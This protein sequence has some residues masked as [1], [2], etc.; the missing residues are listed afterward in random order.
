LITDAANLAVTTLA[1]FCQHISDG[2]G[3]AYPWSSKG[4]E[5][6]LVPVDH[7]IKVLRVKLESRRRWRRLDLALDARLL[8]N[9]GSQRT[10]RVDS[11]MIETYKF[12]N[13]SR[14]RP[15]W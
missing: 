5:H 8:G 11:S 2:V 13:V 9:T 10:I 7:I 6:I 12:A 3:R 1:Y 14:S 15:P 4:N